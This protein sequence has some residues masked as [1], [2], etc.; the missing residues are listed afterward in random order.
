MNL[1]GE[2]GV[3]KTAVVEGLAERIVAGDVPENL[4]NKRVVS[5][6]IASM[7]AGAKYRGDF[8]DRIKKMLKEVQKA[9]DVILF[10]DE[11]H[12]IV[13]AGAAE[14]AID[15]ANILKPLLARGEIQLVG[16]TTLKEYRK[17]IEKD[18]ALERRFSQVMVQE[19]TEDESLQ[20]L[21]G[22]R[23]KYEAHH[24]VK[25]S[26]EAIK[27]CVDLSSRYINDRY[28]PDKAIDLMDEAA[29]RLKMKSYMEPESFKKI[30]DEI[31]KLDKDK[32]DAI[33]VQDFE[34]AAKIR[35]KENDKKKELEKAKKDWKNAKSKQILT[36]KYDDIAEVVAA[37][38]GIPVS[39]VTESE[40]E[41]L[42]NLESNLHKR[43]IGQNEAVEAVAK[44][45][46]RSRLGLKAPNKP[47]GSFLFLGPTGVGKTEL[48]KAL[49][50]SLF[51]TEDA[52]IRIDMSEYMESQSV[53]KLIGAPPGYVGYDE[54]GQL[55]EK[56]RRKP[57]SVILFDEIEKAHPDVMNSLL[58]V[59]DD[60]R[61]TDSQGRTVNFKNT[62][63]IMTSN[64]GARL[65]TEKKTLGFSDKKET[66]DKQKAYE[67]TKKEVLAELKKEFKPEFL[68]RI[69]DIIVFHK[70]EQEDIRKIID[71]MINK[72]KELMSAKDLV[73]KQGF[74][75]NYGARP[76]RRAIQSMIE[77]KVAEAILDGNVKDKAI[78]DCNEDK[79]VVRY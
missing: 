51:G 64:V 21:K 58:Q 32:E 78:V 66:T 48:S 77:D 5:V 33:R 74:D 70:L 71:L 28:L 6:D 22:L 2:P 23:D 36:L 25:I 3:G 57:Y 63:I 18:A 13:G 43:V 30:T 10:I 46:K 42:R 17:F 27:A 44:A 8:E 45:I 53:A 15:A 41:K 65:I 26:D 35:D 12:T 20:I 52:L 61:L 29:S 11:I 50:E 76:L 60:G 31:E 19:P 47:I 73:A 7:V 79:I 24:N 40:S 69:D 16:A 72:V 59:L 54:A 39:K 1:I 56:V 9:K 68:N 55:T 38:T 67:E 49:A 75:Q 4:K 34:K 14:G 62:I 37:W